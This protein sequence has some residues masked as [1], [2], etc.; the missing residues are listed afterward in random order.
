MRTESTTEKWRRRL[1]E[2]ESSGLTLR[3][4]ARQRQ[5]SAKTLDWWRWNLAREA[6]NA[7]S[8]PPR[9]DALTVVPPAPVHTR[10]NA[11][12]QK[13]LHV[14]FERRPIV[15]EIHETVSVEWLRN[16]VDALC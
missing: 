9:F 11:V 7:P 3:E 13:T 5:L 2:W 14:R 15:L 12:L 8:S 16:V 10:A 6:S 4:F 1:I